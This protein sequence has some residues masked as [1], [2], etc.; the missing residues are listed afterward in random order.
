MDLVRVG[1]MLEAMFGFR[2]DQ[3]MRL[4]HM[5][6]VTGTCSH[7]GVD[8]EMSILGGEFDSFAYSGNLVLME[9]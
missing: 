2:L 5:V 7:Q 8:T 1:R 9:S 6:E 4:C 3:M